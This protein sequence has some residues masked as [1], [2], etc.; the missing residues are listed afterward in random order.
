MSYP[1]ELGN[2]VNITQGTTGLIASGT[3]AMYGQIIDMAGYEGVIVHFKIGLVNTASTSNEMKVQMGSSASGGDMVDISG[4]AISFS[5]AHYDYSATIAVHRP[6]ERYIRAGVTHG[7]S[8]EVESITY[9]RY[10]AK[11]YPVANS[12]SQQRTKVTVVSPTS[13]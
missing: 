12:T 4:A 9:I 1:A 6:R 7:S 13:G 10:G 2:A 11:K 5:S 3:S 8:A